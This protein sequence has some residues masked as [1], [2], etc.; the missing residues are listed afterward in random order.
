[1]NLPNKISIFRLLIIPFFIYVYLYAPDLNGYNWAAGILFAV[2][3]LSDFLDGYIARHRNM[4]TP[5]G[6]ILDPL[7]DK[8]LFLASLLCLSVRWRINFLIFIIFSVKEIVVI[9]FNI[10]LLSRVKDVLPSK[11]SGKILTALN[12]LL[13]IMLIVLPD[14]VPSYRTATISYFVLFFLAFLVSFSYFLSY[15]KI[16]KSSNDKPFRRTYE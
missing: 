14:G 4:V 15:K 9:V 13:T 3:A 11:Y 16:I 1:M 8:L 12:S 5:L 10:K 2:A 7:A 6:R